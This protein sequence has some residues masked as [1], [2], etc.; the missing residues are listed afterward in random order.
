MAGILSAC[1]KF[2][3]NVEPVQ[4]AYDDHPIV[5]KST[6]RVVLC[7]ILLAIVAAFGWSYLRY[8]YDQNTTYG[9][10]VRTDRLTGEKCLE[11]GSDSFLNVLAIQRC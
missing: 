1:I 6:T 9:Y 7:V 5:K 11:S 2:P 3:R 10:I 8:S 4:P